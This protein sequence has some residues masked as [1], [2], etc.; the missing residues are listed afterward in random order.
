MKRNWFKKSENIYFITNTVCGWK[1][2][3]IYKKTIELV[4]SCFQYFRKKRNTLL[5]AYVIMP[6][7]LHYIIHLKDKKYD[8]SCYQRDFKKFISKKVHKIFRDSIETKRPL[9]FEDIF[10]IL[11]HNDYY[12]V[13][14]YNYLKKIGRMVNQSFKLWMDDE[15]PEVIISRKFFL[16]KMKYIHENPVRKG[17]VIEDKDYPYS[18]AR[19]YIKLDSDVIDIAEFY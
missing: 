12:F 9:K 4:L 5:Y 13:N 14:S 18:S 6:S 17:L 2:V 7:H 16:Q 3:F 8:I 10:N 1:D 19:D 11:N 15:Q